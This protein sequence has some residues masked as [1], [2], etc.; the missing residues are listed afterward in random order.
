MTAF[1]DVVDAQDLKAG[2]I[3]YCSYRVKVTDTTWELVGAWVELLE[4]PRLASDQTVRFLARPE[5]APESTQRLLEFQN[6]APMVVRAEDIDQVVPD[7]V[8]IGRLSRAYARSERDRVRAVTEL[9]AIK[10]LLAEAQPALE[11]LLEGVDV[12]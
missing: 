5:G 1:I 9:T 7:D 8:A 3:A 2:Q 10:G 4:D 12:P 6:Q 11:R